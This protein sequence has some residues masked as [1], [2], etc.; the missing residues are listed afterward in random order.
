MGRSDGIDRIGDWELPPSHEKIDFLDGFND[1]TVG[2]T[3]DR[4]L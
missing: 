4:A 2:C 3:T 1:S